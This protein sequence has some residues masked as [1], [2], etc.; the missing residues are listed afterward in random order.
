MV[1]HSIDTLHLHILYV[2]CHEFCY[3]ERPFRLGTKWYIMNYTVNL[4]IEGAGCR[5]AAPRSV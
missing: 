5:V 2:L 4:P 3:E 1:F